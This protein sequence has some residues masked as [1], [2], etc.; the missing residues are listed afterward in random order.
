MGLIFEDPLHS[1]DE[2]RFVIIGESTRQRVLVVV[3]T[4]QENTIRIISARVA[5]TR[6]RQTYE[7]GV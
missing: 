3:H 6:E 2:D 1:T 5:T 7:E 4:E